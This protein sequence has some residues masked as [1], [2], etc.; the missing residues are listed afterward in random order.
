VTQ[1]LQAE[2]LRRGVEVDF[3]YARILKEKMAFVVP[4]R[5]NIPPLK[6]TASSFFLPDGDNVSRNLMRPIYVS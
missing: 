4:S 5:V 1:S 2:L 3:A 6:S